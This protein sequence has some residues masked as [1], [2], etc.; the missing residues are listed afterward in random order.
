VVVRRLHDGRRRRLVLV[1]LEGGLHRCIDGMGSVLLG[2]LNLKF[3]FE[4]AGRDIQVGIIHCVRRFANK[5]RV[6]GFELRVRG[7]ADTFVR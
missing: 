2:V 7:E 3:E 4:I 5:S 1:L 6:W